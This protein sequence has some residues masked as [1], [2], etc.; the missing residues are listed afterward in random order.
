MILDKN[1]TENFKAMIICKTNKEKKEKQSNITFYLLTY[2][3][4]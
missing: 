4:H 2:L 3:L 1:Y